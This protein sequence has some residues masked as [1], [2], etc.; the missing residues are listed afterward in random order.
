MRDEDRAILNVILT[1]FR[2][3]I[4]IYCVTR[5]KSLNQSQFGWGIFGFFL[6]LIALI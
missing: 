1:L 6:P 2:I 3:G 5:A 4:T